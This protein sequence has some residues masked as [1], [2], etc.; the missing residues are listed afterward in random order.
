MMFITRRILI[1]HFHEVIFLQKI[2]WYKMCYRHVN[3]NVA[4]LKL[5]YFYYLSIIPLLQGE[6]KLYLFFKMFFFSFC[7]LL[8]YL[9][10]I[11]ENLRASLA[12]FLKTVLKKQLL[13]IIFKNSFQLFTGKKNSDWGP[14][15]EKQFSCL[16][17]HLFIMQNFSKY[18]H[19]F[20]CCLEHYK[21]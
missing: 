19:L 10:Q 6:I 14:K 16:V 8:Y 11:L 3:L 5:V 17:V 15:C 20:N 4:L 12:T 2:H 21:K 18:F 13:K 9:E 1:V 7:H